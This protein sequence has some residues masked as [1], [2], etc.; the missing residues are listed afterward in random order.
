MRA[1]R[2]LQVV[3]GYYKVKLNKKS[4]KRQHVR[5]RQVAQYLMRK[6]TNLSYNS[7]GL[8]FGNADHTTILS[9]IRVIDKLFKEDDKVHDDVCNLVGL[10]EWEKLK[11]AC[12]EVI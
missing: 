1:R 3:E 12:G 11:I 4:R 8:L 9:N 7:I 5:P 2:I 6:Y 10:I